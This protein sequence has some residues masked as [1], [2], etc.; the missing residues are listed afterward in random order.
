MDNEKLAALHG[1][2]ISGTSNSGDTMT[3][4]FTDGSELVTQTKGSTN[5]ASTGGVI[6]SA[7][8]TA[9]TLTLV[10]EGGAKMEIPLAD[11]AE[12]SVTD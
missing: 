3:I 1:R 11:N 6:K 7:E 12:V 10:M 9:D 8:Q 5:S 2:T 4:H